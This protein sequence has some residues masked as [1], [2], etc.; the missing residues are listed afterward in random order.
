[1]EG[2]SMIYEVPTASRVALPISLD[3]R[4][5]QRQIVC[6]DQ[7]PQASSCPRDLLICGATSALGCVQAGGKKIR[8]MFQL[9]GARVAQLVTIA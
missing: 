1:M 9:N 5:V 4:E 7:M 2:P 6:D 3:L 8:T